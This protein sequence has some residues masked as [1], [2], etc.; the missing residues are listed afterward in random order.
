MAIKASVKNSL[1]VGV[2]VMAIA[3]ATRKNANP[4]AYFWKN[5]K[6]LA[7]ILISPKLP[8]AK[9][10]WMKALVMMDG[11]ICLKDGTL[12]PKLAL[13]CLSYTLAVQAIGNTA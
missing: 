12:M 10:K 11:M 13:V 2:K 8:F 7:V 5:P 1:S 6:L 9:W 4:F 3:L